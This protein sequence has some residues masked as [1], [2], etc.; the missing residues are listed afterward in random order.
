MIMRAQGMIMPSLSFEMLRVVT[1][2]PTH[3][4]QGPTRPASRAVAS[5]GLGDPDRQERPALGALRPPGSLD[6]CLG[7]RRA[8]QHRAA[9]QDR[10]QAGADRHLG[11]RAERHQDHAG[12]LDHARRRDP[13]P[14]A[15]ERADR[16]GDLRSRTTALGVELLAALVIGLLVIIFTPNLGPVAPGARRRGRSPPILIG[17]VL[18]LLRAAPLSDRL[19][20]SVA[21]D[22]R[23]LSDADLLPASCASSGSAGRSAACSRNTCRRRWSSSWRSRRKSS[24]SAA[25]SA[26]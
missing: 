9:G 11:G 19:H 21:V 1:G 4:D 7:R 13:C 3:P 16:R 8:R 20:L 25:R 18:V 23:D 22:H 14:G 24:C 12:V 2:T 15:G 26:R 10:R 5:Q 6:L 17:T